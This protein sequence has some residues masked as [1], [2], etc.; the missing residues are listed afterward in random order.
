MF[1]RLAALVLPSN[2]PG[3]PEGVLLAHKRQEEQ[4]EFERAF[5]RVRNGPQYQFFDK[6]HSLTAD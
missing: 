4:R 6:S 1:E 5:D 2:K 3:T